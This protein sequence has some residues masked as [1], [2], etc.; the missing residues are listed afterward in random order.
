MV[1]GMSEPRPAPIPY[2]DRD[3]VPVSSDTYALL[4]AWK[5]GWFGRGVAFGL[6]L[7]VAALLFTIIAAVV[8][9]VI[10]AGLGGPRL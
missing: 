4:K 9:P 8:L 1:A 7:G 5:F 10:G 2:E 6:G 3:G